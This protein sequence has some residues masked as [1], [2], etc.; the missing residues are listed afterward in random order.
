MF[1]ASCH[2]PA[3][4]REP[5]NDAPGPA[6]AQSLAS[7]ALTPDS[8]LGS[9]EEVAFA[10]QT[11]SPRWLTDGPWRLPGCVAY[12]RPLASVAAAVAS[13]RAR[14]AEDTDMKD[15]VVLLRAQGSPHVWPRVWVLEAQALTEERLLAEWTSWASRERSLGQRRCGIARMDAGDGSTIV[16]VVVVDVLA[17]LA[18]L[19][20]RARVG[21]WIRLD[22]SLL[23]A[24][25]SGQL[26][27]LGPDESPRGVPSTLTAG[28]FRSTFSFDRQGYWRLQ[29]LLDVGFGP[30]PALEAWVFVGMEPELEAVLRAAPGEGK[31][32][33]SPAGMS[34]D[35]A[36]SALYS[37]IDAAR[38]SQGL[39]SLER[40]RRLDDLAQA[41]A[42]A[43]LR[44]GRTA[45]DAG[46]GLPLDR[47]ARA[48]LGPRR[49]GEN[50]ARA[51]SIER[52]HRVLWDSPSHR[53]NLLD[54]AYDAIGIGVVNAQAG[55]VLVCEL[56]ADYG[57]V[58]A[59][60]LSPR[61]SASRSSSPDSFSR[62][63]VRSP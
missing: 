1:L 52:A 10:Q 44:N 8:S 42:E 39:P 62:E 31:G 3:D 12:E 21:Q 49:V 19:P 61:R 18:P 59:W 2:S 17:D 57:G 33:P 16:A 4:A 37:M 24:A 22:A 7:P 30:Q 34:P 28:A 36:R 63:L 38:R 50:V 51:R 46:D 48:G 43:M 14:G 47:V 55:D 15:V 6:A 26:L 29:V 23:A 40:D 53:G 35:V 9:G 13:A 60:L 27:L 54:P 58:A 20:L 32:T 56:F 45:H 25:R 11:G 41:H 5:K